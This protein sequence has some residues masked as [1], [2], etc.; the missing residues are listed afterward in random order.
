MSEINDTLIDAAS[1]Y[2]EM[3]DAENKGYSEIDYMHASLDG[4]FLRLSMSKVPPSLNSIL[5]EIEALEFEDFAREDREDEQQTHKV[6]KLEAA[7]A[8]IDFP[9][10][11]EV[12]E[13]ETSKSHITLC[14]PPHLA[15]LLRLYAAYDSLSNYV[16][17]YSDMRFLIKRLIDKLAKDEI[18]YP[19]LTRSDL[20]KDA[21]FEV[22]DASQKSALEHIF[23]QPLSYIWGPP[24]TGKTQMVLFSAIRLLIAKGERLLILAP[25][26]KALDMALDTIIKRLEDLGIGLEILLRL[27]VCSSEFKERYP[28]CVDPALLKQGASLFG[29][30]IKDRI[31]IAQIFGM[32]ID[33]YIYKSLSFEFDAPFIFIDECAFMPF[34]KAIT[35]F[36]PDVNIS[37]FGDHKQLMPVCEIANATLRANTSLAVFSK[38]ALF[39]DEG[40][41]EG[42]FNPHLH[43]IAASEPHIYDDTLCALLYSYRY[44]DNLARLLD[45]NI[46]HSGLRGIA[47]QHL[48]LYYIDS[49]KSSNGAKENLK[50]AA[51]IASL[52]KAIDRGDAIRARTREVA[53]DR[54]GTDLVG[55]SLANLSQ[56]YHILTP[57]RFQVKAL[58]KA[59]IPY[60]NVSTIHTSQGQEYDT[61]ILSVVSFHYYLTNTS[62]L[63]ALYALNVAISRA[64]KSFVLVCDKEFWSGARG[65]FI[66]AILEQSSELLL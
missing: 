19:G 28:M 50:E 48:N 65:Q 39:V 9:L 15:E 31:K 53:H 2:L 3:L 64:K 11:Y 59:G 52:A 56:S 58:K 46:Y 60:I 61:I 20:L 40:L 32:T 24:G 55:N 4:A 63:S 38:S 27:G 26:N 29:Y 8:S 33:T 57:F 1:L 66:R 18:G 17:I 42:L 25:T 5:L 47:T 12:E 43:D 34:I 21:S 36:S 37:L 51:I 41:R 35:A 44:G 14:L 22:M 13:F 23:T 54:A 7:L 45:A 30:G 6:E 62:T 16:Y 49:G 10:Y